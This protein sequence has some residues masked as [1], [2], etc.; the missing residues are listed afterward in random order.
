MQ[1]DVARKKYKKKIGENSH[2]GVNYLKRVKLS[3][4]FGCQFWWLSKL[5]PAGMWT[6]W[7]SVLCGP[8]NSWC[9][10]M[11][12]GGAPTGTKKLRP[13][14]TR[15]ILVLASPVLVHLNGD[16]R[17]WHWQDVRFKQLCPCWNT[18]RRGELFWKEM[19]LKLFFFKDKIRIKPGLSAEVAERWI[20][21]I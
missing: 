6:P 12:V 3:P 21:K 20:S 1:K 4:N 10:Q 7:W 15:C 18:S 5:P 2:L 13:G 17:K 11:L 19:L 9:H 16:S 8:G 14:L